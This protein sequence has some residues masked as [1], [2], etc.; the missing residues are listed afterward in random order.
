MISNKIA[1]TMGDPAGIGPE[2]AVKALSNLLAYEDCTP[3][4]VGD[5]VVVNEV[6]NQFNIDVESEVIKEEDISKIRKKDKCIYVLN[7][8]IVNNIK[9]LKIGKASKLGGKASYLYLKK[10]I[11]LA[12]KKITCGIATAPINKESI[13][14]Y[15]ISEIGHTEILAGLTNSINPVTMFVV[16]KMKIFFYTRHVSL[17]EAIE[18]L[19]V[20]SIYDSLVLSYKSMISLGYEKPVIALAALNP[21]ASDGGL[22]GNEENDILKPACEKAKMKGINVIGPVPADSVF[23]QCLEGKYDAVV[24][25]YHD[26]G[27]IAAKTYNFF[28]TISVTLGLPFIRTSVDHG[29]AFDIA[30]KGIANPLSMIEAIVT[31]CKLSMNYKP[32]N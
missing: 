30:W 31:G 12:N 7:I 28:K 17:R 2:I 19:D 29:T 4:L 27:H 25:L 23:H 21:H 15:G 24:S 8:G 10:G 16:D 13:K 5:I 6:I 1:I 18:K 11:E 32:L 26:Q 22:F 9:D 14:L 3:I 20:D